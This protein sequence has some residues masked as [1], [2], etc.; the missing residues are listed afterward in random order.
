MEV[1]YDV[2]E[3]LRAPAADKP[4]AVYHARDLNFQ[5]KAGGKAV[6]SGTRL[7]NV[8]D[9][10]MGKAPD[11]GAYEMGRPVPLYGPRGAGI[12]AVE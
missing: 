12:R 4:Q 1:D 2:F 5:L 8:N 10:F 3:N 11:L 9:D 6:D 7:L